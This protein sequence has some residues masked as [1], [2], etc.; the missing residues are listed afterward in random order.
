[1]HGTLHAALRLVLVSSLTAYILF[2]LSSIIYWTILRDFL[3]TLFITLINSFGPSLLLDVCSALSTV[4]RAYS[5]KFSFSRLMLVENRK[6][7]AWGHTM[8]VIPLENWRDCHGSLGHGKDANLG[9]SEHAALEVPAAESLTYGPQAQ[10]LSVGDPP[11]CLAETAQ[12]MNSNDSS[13]EQSV[14]ST[15][16]SKVIRHDPGQLSSELE[17]LQRSDSSAEEI[18]ASSDEKKDSSHDV[19]D[20]PR[21]GHAVEE[22]PFT[23]TKQVSMERLPSAHLW[24][25]SRLPTISFHES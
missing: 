23:E 21:K 10:D 20:E 4:F 3:A 19:D 13:R 15:E 16:S 8:I 7:Q 22:V 18:D 6:T 9:K 2:H 25:I 14:K 11:P 24:L 12:E 1:M 17:A 5:A